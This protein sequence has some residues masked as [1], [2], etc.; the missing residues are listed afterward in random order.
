MSEIKP[1]PHTSQAE[2]GSLIEQLNKWDWFRQ[3]F[4]CIDFVAAVWYHFYKH[5]IFP[6]TEKTKRAQPEINLMAKYFL[7]SLMYE[8]EIAR[9]QISHLSNLTIILQASHKRAMPLHGSTLLV[10]E[11]DERYTMEKDGQISPV[12]LTPLAEWSTYQDEFPTYSA[13]T[14]S[15]AKI[16]LNDNK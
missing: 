6:S 9:N 11:N 7:Y 16:L 12:T 13:Q 14:F 10:D 2:I 5:P 15:V 4:A 3:E 8:N 1:V